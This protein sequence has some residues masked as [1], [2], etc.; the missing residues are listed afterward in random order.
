MSRTWAVALHPNRPSPQPASAGG[1]N[2]ACGAYARYL[3]SGYIELQPLGRTFARHI[4]L[5]FA[6][7]FSFGNNVP[8]LKYTASMAPIAMERSIGIGI[9][10]PKNFEI[11]ATQHQVDFL[12]RYAGNVGPADLGPNGPYG[13]YT[14]AGVRWYFGGYSGAR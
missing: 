6:P 3:A 14:T 4:F 5:F 1:A 7:T 8:Q 12:G 9:K 2:S 11:R 10:L 13:I